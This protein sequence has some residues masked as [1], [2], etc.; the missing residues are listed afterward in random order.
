MSLK[1]FHILFVVLSSTLCFAFAG[2]ALGTAGGET[3]LYQGM[4]ITSLAL[5]TALIV[6]GFWFW[7][8]IK[9]IQRPA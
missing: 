4:G 9:R 6:Y 5:G 3:P 7:K 2:W 8:K 1:A